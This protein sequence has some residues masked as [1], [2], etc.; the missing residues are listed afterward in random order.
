MADFPGVTGKSYTVAS[1][2]IRFS[3][4]TVKLRSVTP[5]GREVTQ[6][7][8]FEVG[9]RV[10]VA[11]VTGAEKPREVA[12]EY[13]PASYAQWA[14]QQDTLALQR[15]SI[16]ILLTEPGLPSITIDHEDCGFMGD[17]FP[18]LTAGE[19]TEFKPTG[20]WLPTRTKLTGKSLTE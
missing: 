13:D 9:R 12:V 10:P 2:V 1:M 19:A 3:G 5:G 16:T 4:D 17:E 8:V 7:H 18:Q 15:P 14:G 20:K 6:E 11:V